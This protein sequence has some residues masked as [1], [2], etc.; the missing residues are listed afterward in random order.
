MPCKGVNGQDHIVDVATASAHRGVF[1]MSSL[2]I[3]L[4]ETD[5]FAELRHSLV[6]ATQWRGRGSRRLHLGLG[7]V[8]GISVALTAWSD[9]GRSADTLTAPAAIHARSSAVLSTHPMFTFCGDLGNAS[10]CCDDTPA[11]AQLLA[12]TVFHP[13]S[14]A[15][16]T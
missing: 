8:I 13:P 11:C 15:L 16:R 10:S 7:A 2:L 14:H 5:D 1:P 12:T 9:A 3:K 4:R 6:C